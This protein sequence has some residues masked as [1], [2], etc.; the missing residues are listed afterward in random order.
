MTENGYEKYGAV[1][2]SNILYTSLEAFNRLLTYCP[3]NVVF[4]EDEY[5]FGEETHQALEDARY[6]C[7]V[8]EEGS[9]LW[10]AETLQKDA[11]KFFLD[12]S[13]EAEAESA[14]D[15]EYEDDED[16]N[17]KPLPGTL[18]EGTPAAHTEEKVA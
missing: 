1:I 16:D 5:A 13:Y 15:D 4:C 9:T 11:S 10:V 7:M 14:E 8:S 2:I 12:F 18:L 17:E 3:E 6:V